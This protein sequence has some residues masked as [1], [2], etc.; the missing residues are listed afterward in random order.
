MIHST[1]VMPNWI[2]DD[3]KTATHE[4]DEKAAVLLAGL[5]RTRSGLRLSVREVLWVPDHAYSRRTPR[6]LSILSEG[7]VPALTK[8]EDTGMVP[9]WLHT[10]PGHNALGVR[11]E[12][13]EIVDD[14][15]SETFRVRSGAR[16]Y[17]SIVISPGDN[18]M[19]FSGIV[20]DG[21]DVSSL[22]RMLVV[23]PRWSLIAAVDVPIE[24]RIPTMF[25]RQVRA[26]GGDLQQV[27]SNLT[28]AIV[29]CGG[30]G[31]AVGEQLARLGVRSMLLVDPDEL[32]D[33][34]V[35]RVY[36]STP[37]KVG[38]P[39]VQVLGDHLKRIAPD[40]VI[41]TVRNK[42]TEQKIARQ[43]T[44]CDVVFGC[45]DDN[46]GRLVLSRLSSYYLT[47][48]I[49]MG[50]LLSSSSGLLQG[51]DGR[52]TVLFPGEACLVCRGRVD[53][54][55]AQA[56][57][58]DSS[59]RESLQAEG[60]APELGA[61]EPAVIPFTSIVASIAVAELI[62]RFVGYGPE[63]EPG[64]ILARCHEREISTNSRAPTPHHYCDP[65]AGQF[66]TGDRAPFLGQTW[67]S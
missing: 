32:S 66:A 52:V 6:S 15:L 50:V 51:I 53:L 9:I 43:L 33:S 1:I 12:Y 38:C 27:L 49:D 55:R 46:A 4:H 18:L 35:T 2:A 57:Q 63:P 7:Y 11:S 61:I 40:A 29:G 16:V 22:Q 21:D 37:S 24:E 67:R 26:F 17:A 42:I 3:L 56:E 13:D 8:A 10:H 31:S 48:V 60:Y 64:E 28:V 59:E 62:E 41:R 25:D 47:P 65:D 45:T 14:E 39:K 44:E 36:G 54:A 58:L 34:N 20:I 19:R 30:T 5:A 23:G